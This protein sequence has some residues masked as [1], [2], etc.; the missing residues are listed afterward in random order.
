MNTIF[1]A[2]EGFPPA[3]SQ[4]RSVHWADRRSRPVPGILLHSR[5]LIRPPTTCDEKRPYISVA[6]RAPLE[7]NTMT[8]QERQLIDDLFDRL[9]RLENSPRDPDAQG[10]IA[11]G[12]RRR[13]TVYALVKTALV[14][15]EALKRAGAAFRNKRA[16][17]PEQQPSPAGSSIPC[18]KPFRQEQRRGSRKAQC[19]MSAPPG[20]GDRPSGTAAR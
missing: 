1:L 16:V 3:C 8:P 17:H 5:D 18:A 4:R 7:E 10:A 15:D 12:L 6:L 14:Q 19:R 20:I 2:G 9:S 11:R 13:N